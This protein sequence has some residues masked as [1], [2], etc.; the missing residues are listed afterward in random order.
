[1]TAKRPMQGRTKSERQTAICRRSF[2]ATA[3]DRLRGGRLNAERLGQGLQ[4]SVRVGGAEPATD[5]KPSDVP[6]SDHDLLVKVSV[7]FRDD[8]LQRLSR[9]DQLTGTPASQ[10]FAGLV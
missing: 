3:G 5:A 8:P 10:L 2:S 9:E 7:V 1:M 4:K 6:V